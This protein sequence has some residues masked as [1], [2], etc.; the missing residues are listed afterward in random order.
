MYLSISINVTCTLYV[1]GMVVKVIET[2]ACIVLYC[3]AC[4]GAFMSIFS[5]RLKAPHG[6]ERFEACCQ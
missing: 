2:R 3:I 6:D 5:N 4:I 1:N